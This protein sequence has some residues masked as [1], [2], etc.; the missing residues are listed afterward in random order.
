M[1]NMRQTKPHVPPVSTVQLLSSGL[2]NG[3]NDVLRD[4]VKLLENAGYR[5]Q[6]VPTDEQPALWFGHY[7]VVGQEAI[8]GFVNHIVKEPK[9]G[10]HCDNTCKN[11]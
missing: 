1:K 2:N 7:E 9:S 5:V 4:C 11:R 8:V 10:D 6:F 3:L